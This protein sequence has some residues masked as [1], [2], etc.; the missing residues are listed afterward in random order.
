MSIFIQ[1]E[2]SLILTPKDFHIID[3]AM[4]AAEPAKPAYSDDG[5]REAVGKAVIRLYTS[6]MTDPGRLAEA[7][8]TMAATRLLDRRRWR[9]DC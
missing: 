4:R 8:S 2:S 3:H 6:G 1:A 5:H 7:A 9:A